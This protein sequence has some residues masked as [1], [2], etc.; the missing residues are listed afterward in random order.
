MT[1]SPLAGPFA[2]GDPFLETGEGADHIAAS[3]AQFTAARASIA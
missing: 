2:G 3:V 1:A